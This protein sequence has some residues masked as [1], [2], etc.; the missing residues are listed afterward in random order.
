MQSFS[1]S[2]K[3]GLGEGASP[4]SPVH[5]AQSDF[6]LLRPGIRVYPFVFPFVN[7]KRV[8]FLFCFGSFFFVITIYQL[9]IFRF[10][11]IQVLLVILCLPMSHMI[12]IFL[13]FRFF[14]PRLFLSLRLS[15][16]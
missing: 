16:G 11:M 6:I 14:L 12:A 3:A 10:S 8:F 4:V 5:L 15:C 13:F 7:R 2:K 9:F 1:G